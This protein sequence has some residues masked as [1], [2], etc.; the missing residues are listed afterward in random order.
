M[1]LSANIYKL[2]YR[3]WGRVTPLTEDGYTL[4]LMVPGDLPVFLKIAMD[5]CGRQDPTHR[6]ETFV[7]PDNHTPEFVRAYQHYKKDWPDTAIRVLPFGPVEQWAA[8]RQ[9]NP[10]LNN[11]LQLKTAVQNALTR[12]ALWHDADLFIDDRAFLKDHYEQ[13]RGRDLACL[14]VSPG[15]NKQFRELGCTHLAATWEL[16]FDVAWARSFAPWRHRGHDGTFAGKP[17]LYD[18][19]FYAQAHT[20]PARVAL[21][22]D[23]ERKFVHFNYVISSYRW[24]QRGLR[25]NGGPYEDKNF[26]LLLV[27]LLI[28]AYDDSGWPYEVPAV[29]ELARGLTDAKAPVTYVTETVRG[30]WAEFRG[31]FQGLLEG[32]LVD[33]ARKT[34]LADGIAPFDRA[35]GV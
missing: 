26:R 25:N 19:L 14:G 18:S 31:K 17:V 28:D 3:R 23:A 4:L 21:N 35:L 29:A 9:N 20:D 1:G 8:R 12:T 5:V 33:A 15:W 24:F 22:A 11:W 13:L 10:G 32:D 27:R 16:M 6:V 2:L 30:Q 7:L 34:K